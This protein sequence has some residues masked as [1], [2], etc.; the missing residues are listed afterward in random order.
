MI[1]FKMRSPFRLMDRGQ[2]R[3]SLTRRR[4]KRTGEL[5]SA[6]FGEDRSRGYQLL[7]AAEVREL[8]AQ[9]TTVDSPSPQ[10]E[11]VARELSRS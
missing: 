9:S 4:R 3:R 10:S 1:R 2:S 11:S 5:R 6:E 7:K 8:I